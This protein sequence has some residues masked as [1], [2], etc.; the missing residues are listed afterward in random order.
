MQKYLKPQWFKKYSKIYQNA[1]LKG[2]IKEGGIK[3]IITFFLFYL[4]RD[5]ILYI[6][7]IYIGLKGMKSCGF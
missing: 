4:I 1:G 2:I 6:L 7:P 3:L 5:T